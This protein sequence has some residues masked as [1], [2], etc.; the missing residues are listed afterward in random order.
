MIVLQALGEAAAAQGSFAA[1]QKLYRGYHKA[2]RAHRPLVALF[3]PQGGRS[4]G[5]PLL[6]R[7]GPAVSCLQPAEPV[8]ALSQSACAPSHH[9]S[10]QVSLISAGRF[11]TESLHVI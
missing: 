1:V 6:I 10:S 4:P 7:Q 9:A 8:T 2:E 3:C 11:L 5:A